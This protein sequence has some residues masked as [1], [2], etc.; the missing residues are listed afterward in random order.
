MQARFRSPL[1]SRATVASAEPAARAT[2]L[3]LLLY[4]RFRSLGG[5]AETALMPDANRCNSHYR[6][7]DVAAALCVAYTVA[8][9]AGRHYQGSLA[10][11]QRQSSRVLEYLD[12]AARARERAQNARDVGARE[13]SERM[14]QSWMKLAASAAFAERVDL[15]LAT[16]V[17]PAVPSNLCPQCARLMRLSVVET[18]KHRHIYSFECTRCGYV[19]RRQIVL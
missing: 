11:L 16:I 15:F 19:Q 5:R 10:L 4:L 13:F 8:F 14:E 3:C 18:M 7:I 6:P 2:A 9:S 12:H 17:R 1:A